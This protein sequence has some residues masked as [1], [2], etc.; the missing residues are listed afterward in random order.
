MAPNLY[1]FE[2]RVEGNRTFVEFRKLR[3]LGRGGRLSPSLMA[4]QSAPSVS[5]PVPLLDE[6]GQLPVI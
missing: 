2:D 4:D 5:T 1:I 6:V 3:F